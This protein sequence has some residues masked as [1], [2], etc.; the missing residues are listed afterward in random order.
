M[1][2]TNSAIIDCLR[3]YGPSTLRDIQTKLDLRGIVLSQN[4]IETRAER[5]VNLGYLK[6]ATGFEDIAYKFA[7]YYI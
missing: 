2:K 4:E 7:R 5:L 1:E 6:P 3:F